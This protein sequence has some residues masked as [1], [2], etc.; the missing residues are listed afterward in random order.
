MES[1]RNTMARNN[2]VIKLLLNKLNWILKAERTTVDGIV[3]IKGKVRLRVW[4]GTE[5]NT[6]GVNGDKIDMNDKR[7][8]E[9]GPRNNNSGLYK[10]DKNT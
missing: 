2:M 3:G 4:N 9:E 10:I 7:K 6:K 8:P 1:E 5:G